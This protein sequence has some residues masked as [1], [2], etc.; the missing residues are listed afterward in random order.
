MAQVA[1]T[2][3]AEHFGP[4]HAVARI[5][6][7]TDAFRLDGL[8]IAGPATP[9]VKLGVRGKQGG[10][11]ADTSV[12]AMLVVVPVSTGKG[13]LGPLHAGNSVFLG[14]KLLPP[15]DISFIDFLH[16]ERLSENS[17]KGSLA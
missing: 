13:S 17:E 15:L 5:P 14:G 3:V 11:A 8:K 2:D 9:C 16:D 4:N 7:F 1:I 6:L 12:N 10:A